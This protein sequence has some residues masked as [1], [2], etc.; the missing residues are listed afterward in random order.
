MQRKLK[1]QFISRISKKAS[2][3]NKKKNTKW[4]RKFVKSLSDNFSHEKLDWPSA[5]Q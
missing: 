2:L 1:A 4:Q 5:E 3:S